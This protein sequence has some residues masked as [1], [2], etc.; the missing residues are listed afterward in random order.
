MLYGFFYELKL[1]FAIHITGISPLK[2]L[3]LSPSIW[4][5]LHFVFPQQLSWLVLTSKKYFLKFFCKNCLNRFVE[6]YCFWKIERDLKPLQHA[7][8]LFLISSQ[9]HKRMAIPFSQPLCTFFFWASI[10]VTW[11]SCSHLL[12][13]VWGDWLH[14]FLY[15]NISA[16]VCVC[17]FCLLTCISFLSVFFIQLVHAFFYLVLLLLV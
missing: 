6:N 1:Q 13:C 12:A 16:C 10:P 9:P 5:S 17:V 2:N 15:T 3:S 7:F 4:I 11:W 8:I 14:L